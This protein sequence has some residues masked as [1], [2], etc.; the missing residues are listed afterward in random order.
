MM[1]LLVDCEADHS[2]YGAVRNGEGAR[3]FG[4]DQSMGLGDAVKSFVL[5]CEFPLD[6]VNVRRRYS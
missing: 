4:V 2:S 3:Q 6:E 5:S 1:Y